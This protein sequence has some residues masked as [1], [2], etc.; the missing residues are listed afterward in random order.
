MP[1]RKGS[2]EERRTVVIA[3]TET[4]HAV[5]PRLAF[6]YPFTAPPVVVGHRGA[7]LV[8]PENTPASF[9]AAVDAGATWVELDVRRS[10]DDVLVVIHDA[11]TADGIP[12]VER[13]AA[14]LADVGVWSLAAVCAALPAELGIDAELKHF[15][16]EPDFDEGQRSATLLAAF[17]TERVRERPWMTSSFDPLAVAL[18]A[19]ALPGVPA[20]LLHASATPM[21]RAATVASE[22]GARILCPHRD[23][24]DLAEEGVRAAHEHGQAV[25]VWTVDDPEHAARLAAMGV[26]AICTNDPAAVSSRL[27]LPSAPG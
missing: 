12:V 10:S 21:A 27:G 16:G 17:L 9:L 26:D 3:T 6:M 15:P 19:E 1:R 24:P 11:A 2:P 22:I 23:V 13:T 4:G 20:G 14:A 5:R 18:L 7:P 25:L 8:A